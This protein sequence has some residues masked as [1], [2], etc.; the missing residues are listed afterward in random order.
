V[1]DVVKETFAVTIE[2]DPKTGNV[3]REVWRNQKGQVSN[4]IGP[5][6]LQYDAIT[7]NLIFE[8]WVINNES[9]RD[10]NSGPA[11]IH[12]DRETGI[13]VKES[14]FVGGNAHR[15]DGPAEIHRNA[16]TGKI[17]K[18]RYFKNDIEFNYEP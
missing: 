9:S 7:K 12:Y 1:N 18:S 5:A 2:S 11:M 8:N 4:P 16:K 15:E 6:I 3:L 10:E 13:A 14:Y 17:T